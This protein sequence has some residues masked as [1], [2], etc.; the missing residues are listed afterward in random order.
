MLAIREEGSNIFECGELGPRTGKEPEGG[1]PSEL[2]TYQ[3][4]NREGARG[5]ERNQGSEREVN[6]TASL[7]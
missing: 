3:A 5:R 2:N 7:T 4:G 1:R 6:A